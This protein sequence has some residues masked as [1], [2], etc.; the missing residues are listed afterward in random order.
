MYISVELQVVALDIQ[1][2]FVTFVVYAV[3]RMVKVDIS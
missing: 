1:A 3:F 2:E